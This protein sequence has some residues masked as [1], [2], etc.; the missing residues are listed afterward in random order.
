MTEW[1]IGTRSL[2]SPFFIFQVAETVTRKSTL[3]PEHCAMDNPSRRVWEKYRYRHI[4]CYL[5][6]TVLFVQVCNEWIIGTAEDIEDDAFA[7]QMPSKSFKGHFLG[8]RELHISCLERC[9]YFLSRGLHNYRGLQYQ[10]FSSVSCLQGQKEPL[11]SLPVL[12]PL[13]STFVI[14]RGAAS[15]PDG[16]G[17]GV[18]HSSGAH[19]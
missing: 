10:L 12:H 17:G 7:S 9:I 16:R 2:R 8:N 1:A 4:S 3:S 15:R 5:A 6:V 14:V 18:H 19:Q 13:I 11:S